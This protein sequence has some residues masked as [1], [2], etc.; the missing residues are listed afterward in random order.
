VCPYVRR[1]RC[2]G[3]NSSGQLGDNT[4]T[5]ST[6]P[7][8]V[9]DPTDTTQAHTGP[10]PAWWIPYSLLKREDPLLTPNRKRAAVAMLHDRFGCPND[11]RAGWSVSTAPLSG[12]TL[13]CRP[14]MRPNSASSFRAFAE[15]RPRWGWRRAAKEL[16]RDGWKVNNKRVRRLWRDE[17]LQV[18]TKTRKKR[19]SGV[20]ANVGAMC[21]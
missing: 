10:C 7:V 9:V 1:H 16:R 15:R 6:V 21:R 5:Y 4:N 8:T 17:G 12:L 2:W 11:E 13:P 3:D 20:G 14:T 19:L 18:P